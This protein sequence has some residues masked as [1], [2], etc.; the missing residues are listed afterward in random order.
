MIAT[1]ARAVEAENGHEV[2]LQQA[3]FVYDAGIPE[4]RR[5]PVFRI[6]AEGGENGGQSQ[7]DECSADLSFELREA[8]EIER[9][10][11]GRRPETESR[12]SRA[13]REKGGLRLMARKAGW[14]R[15]RRA[16]AQRRRGR[17]QCEYAGSAQSSARA[18]RE[19]AGRCLR[20]RLPH[21]EQVHDLQV[22][23]DRQEA[24]TTP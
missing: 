12:A 16:T 2:A 13:V 20:H 11:A 6:C 5:S 21:V 22:V 8:A 4:S 18:I 1:Q 24:V 17:S 15:A 9:E 19:R 10:P 7:W 14:P 23:T 3:D